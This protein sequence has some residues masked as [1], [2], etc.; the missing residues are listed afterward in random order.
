MNADTKTSVIKISEF[1]EI[2]AA[3]IECRNNGEVSSFYDLIERQTPAKQKKFWRYF[4]RN[5]TQ[6]WDGTWVALPATFGT[7]GYNAKDGE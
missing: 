3:I 6:H 5:T 7:L 1:E 4:D 2:T